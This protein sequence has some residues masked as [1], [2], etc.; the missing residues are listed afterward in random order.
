[1]K[2]LV[3][4]LMMLVFCFV[5]VGAVRA[6]DCEN[7]TGL[8]GGLCCLK[9]GEFSCDASKDTSDRKNI[10]KFNGSKVCEMVPTG[11]INTCEDC[12]NTSFGME[13]KADYCNRSGVAKEPHCLDD[14]KC[15]CFTTSEWDKYKNGDK[16]PG[17]G[18]F[19]PSDCSEW[20][21][22]GNLGEECCDLVENTGVFGKKYLSGRCNDGFK[23]CLGNPEDK[24]ENIGKCLEAKDVCGE[25]IG[26]PCC[27]LILDH[28]GNCDK[29]PELKCNVMSGKCE[30]SQTCV[31][32]QPDRYGDCSVKETF[33]SCSGNKYSFCVYNGDG[34]CGWTNIAKDGQNCV[35]LTKEEAEKDPA[36]NGW[37]KYFNGGT[38]QNPFC[39]GAG[40]DSDSPKISTALGCVPINFIEFVAWIFKN[41]FGIV[42]GIAFLLLIFAFIQLATSEG[43]VK[44]IQ[45][46][47]ETITSIATG[48]LLALF[49]IFIIRMLMINILHIPGLQ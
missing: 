33:D 21:G 40:E 31:C 38:K 17:G 6:A 32:G 13:T 25:V 39:D 10:C 44:K 12:T 41:G 11:K 45:G 18:E 14:N 8:E 15:Q 27:D 4:V 35:C 20:P 47:K 29:N 3:I 24:T 2:K 48:L 30:T 1:M 34:K 36:Y 42:G 28:S 23:C 49:S 5:G 19:A 22:T 7:G 46:V 16:P 43:D 37:N 9:N 26:S